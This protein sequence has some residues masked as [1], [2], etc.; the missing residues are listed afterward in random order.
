[1]LFG[2]DSTDVI[3]G[4]LT[5]D[6][7]DDA[8]AVVNLE[9]KGWARGAVVDRYMEGLAVERMARVNDRDGLDGLM[10]STS[11]TCHWTSMLLRF[12]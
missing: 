10:E 3:G 9:G 2:S 12:L 6:P 8:V 5:G 7:Q 1:L 4:A 11:L